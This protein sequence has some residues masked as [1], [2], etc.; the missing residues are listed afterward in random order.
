VLAAVQ[1]SLLN[2]EN[3][4]QAIE[5][6]GEVLEFLYP[7]EST[8]P[9]TSPPSPTPPEITP[10]ITAIDLDWSNNKSDWSA[11]DGI[12]PAG[13]QLALNS[14]EEYYY[15]DVASLTS[16]ILLKDGEYGF[17]V[18]PDE[19]DTGYWNDKGVNASA[20]GSWEEHMYDIITGDQPIFYLQVSDIGTTFML[21]DGLQK[22]LG[23][24]EYLRISGD[25]PTGTYNYTGTVTG[26]N[27]VDS[28]EITATITFIENTD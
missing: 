16:N 25:Y 8:P 5:V 14:A 28:E 24:D 11:V 27:N 21:L 13:Y 17:Y 7:G 2:G 1:Q 6:I 12:L 10:E 26:E 20:S 23:S 22:L 4:G 19:Q 15:L 18:D 9:T 3:P